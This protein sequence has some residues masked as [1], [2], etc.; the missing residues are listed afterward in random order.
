MQVII[1]APES[2]TIIGPAQNHLEM[3]QTL[4]IDSVEVADF[5][6]EQVRECARM[7]AGLDAQRKAI[8]K[9]LDEA[10][11]QVMDLF[12]PAL[13]LLDQ[14]KRT[15][16]NKVA[17][18]QRKLEDER[19]RKQAEVEA[20][21][22]KERERLAREAADAQAKADF[23]ANEL[24]LKAAD[25]ELAGRTA[26]AAKMLARA[27]TKEEAGAAKAMDLTAEAAA[28]PSTVV[29]P[30]VPT[31]AGISTR[32]LWD[33]EIVDPAQLPR[34][35]LM[36]D[37]KAIRGVVKAMKG[38]TAIPGVRVFNRGSVAVSK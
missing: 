20:A 6:S 12:R 9:P 36:P 28:I 26:E 10:K 34:E 21:A 24:R 38:K 23:E 5:V 17:E 7:Y 8:T 4:T 32:E 27:E 13:D 29:L 1:T 15:G 25:A 30:T 33:F 3:M 22:R 31:F 37:E 2:S 19:R 14:A 11:Q 16:G 35:Y 18:Y